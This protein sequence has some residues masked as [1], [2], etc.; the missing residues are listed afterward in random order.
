MLKREI[1]IFSANEEKIQHL[2]RKR[3]N[4]VRF[5][6]FNDKEYVQAHSTINSIIYVFECKKQKTVFS[7]EN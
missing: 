1:E 6:T 2:L 3:D 4:I 5:S 7:T